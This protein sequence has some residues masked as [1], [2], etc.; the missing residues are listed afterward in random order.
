MQRGH[1]RYLLAAAQR[2]VQVVSMK[3]DDVELRSALQ[4]VFEH[5]NVVRHPVHAVLIHTQ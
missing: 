4:H 1:M 5:Q 3:M 2:K